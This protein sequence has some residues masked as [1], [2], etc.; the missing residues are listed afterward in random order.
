MS[1]VEVE[2]APQLESMLTPKVPCYQT[3][4]DRTKTPHIYSYITQSKIKVASME[5]MEP[6]P[7][8][9]SLNEEASQDTTA[10][11]NAHDSALTI[12]V[13]LDF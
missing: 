1:Q 7:L 11:V 2:A 5:I 9:S 10:N 3:K 6:S 4:I 8:E 13:R 12:S